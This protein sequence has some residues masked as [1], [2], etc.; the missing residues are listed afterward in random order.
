MSLKSSLRSDRSVDSD[1]NSSQS[2]D[3]RDW[4][5]PRLRAELPSEAEPSALSSAGIEDLLVKISEA[6]REHI[7][8]GIKWALGLEKGDAKPQSK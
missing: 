7:T 2:S 5:H 8:G 1:T 3:E 6:Y 4:L